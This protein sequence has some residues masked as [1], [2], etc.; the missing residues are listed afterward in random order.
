MAIVHDGLPELDALESGGRDQKIERRKTVF[1]RR[2][3][4]DGRSFLP[5]L[6][7]D[8]AQPSAFLW[9]FLAVGGSTHPDRISG[10]KVEVAFHIPCIGRGRISIEKHQIRELR[11]RCQPVSAGRTTWAAFS[12]FES[13]TLQLLEFT[14]Q[15]FMNAWIRSIVVGDDLKGFRSS[16]SL[17]VNALNQRSDVL[18]VA[19]D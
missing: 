10:Q 17:K 3:T 7:I 19:G 13:N 8:P 2:R 14:L 9:C 11:L 6:A 18:L 5:G 15:H 4:A 16:P 1:P 12:C